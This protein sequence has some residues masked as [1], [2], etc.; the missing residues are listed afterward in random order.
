MPKIKAIAFDLMGVIVQENDVPLT[1]VEILLESKFGLINNDQDYYIW[2]RQKTDLPIEEINILIDSIATKRYT[3]R[4]PDLFT[5]IPKFKFATAT[6][7]ISRIDQGWFKHQPIAQN[8][9][10]FF[11]SSNTGVAKP[12]PEFYKKLIETI[13]EKLSEVL[14]V[15]DKQENILGAQRVGLQVLHYQGGGFLSER[16]KEILTPQHLMTPQRKYPWQTI[17]GKKNILLVAQHNSLTIRQGKLKLPESNTGEIV[18]KICIEKEYWGMITN[19]IQ[20]DPNW[21]KNS[22]F[23]KKALEVIKLNNIKTV[24]DFHER[25]PDYPELIEFLPN[26]VFRKKYPECLKL[27]ILK[28]FKNDQQLTLSEELDRLGVPGLEIEICWSKD[29]INKV[30]G[31]INKLLL[32]LSCFKT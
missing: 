7:H 11:S 31:V 27:A 29:Q 2:A 19:F 16:I 6:N 3:I 20:K 15:D 17:E 1:P 4:E 24:L 30:L 26:K 10:Y 13:K 9:D 21:Y 12:N 25:R 18:K 5:K 8:F 22:L 23:R 32:M 14:F 28:N